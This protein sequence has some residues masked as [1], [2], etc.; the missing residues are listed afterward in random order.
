LTNRRGCGTFSTI[1][2]RE[3]RAT[4][5]C[6]LY[7]QPGTLADRADAKAKGFV[8]PSFKGCG[9]IEPGGN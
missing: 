7:G 3:D 1:A 2:L 9:R 4:V 8:A 6:G 5:A